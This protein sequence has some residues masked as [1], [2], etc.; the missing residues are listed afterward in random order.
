MSTYFEG[1]VVLTQNS[2]GHGFASVH[3][4]CTFDHVARYLD[5]AELP[6]AGTVCE[7]DQKP[8]VDVITKRGLDLSPI[9]RRWL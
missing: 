6:E 9:A 4:T 2:G 7:T 8:L 1:S 3:S 5:T